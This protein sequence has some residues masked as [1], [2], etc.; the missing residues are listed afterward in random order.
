MLF[1]PAPDPA[2]KFEARRLRLSDDIPPLWI[3]AISSRPAYGFDK[4]DPP[5]APTTDP[6]YTEQEQHAST[7]FRR[8][9]RIM[10]FPEEFP[11]LARRRVI[12]GLPNRVWSWGKFVPRSSH[13]DSCLG[14][15]ETR[16]ETSERTG[17]RLGGEAFCFVPFFERCSGR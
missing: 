12:V 16:S 8:L 14:G 1:I 4:A 3:T 11:I 9:S 6:L 10:Q 17:Q 2:D 5:S 15:I 13:S 7:L